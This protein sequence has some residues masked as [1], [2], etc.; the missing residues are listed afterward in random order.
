MAP[1]SSV[2]SLKP[3]PRPRPKS[4]P[5]FRDQLRTWRATAAPS[6]NPQKSHPSRQKRGPEQSESNNRE[7]PGLNLDDQPPTSAQARWQTPPICEIDAVLDPF[8]RFPA[9]LP[10]DG[11][12]LIHF[13]ITTIA[14]KIYGT[15]R[16]PGFSSVRDVSFV[17]ALTS[18]FT[19]QWMVISAEALLM[20]YRGAPEP[21]SLFRRKAVAYLALQKYLEDFSRE[22]VTD[23]IVSGL[24]MAIIAESRIAGPQV[25]N[26]HL[27][28]YEAVIKVGGGLR[29]VLAASPRPFD[30]MSHFMPYLICEPLA[31]AL[32]FSEEFEDQAMDLL[33]IIV[34]G[35]SSADPA[36]L[37]FTVSHEIARPQVLF[38]SLRGSLPQQ[39]RRLLLFSVIAP[40]LRVDMWEGRLYVQKSSHFLSLFLLV[41]TFWKLRH[42]Y[43]SQTAF[44]SSLYRLFMN[45]ATRNQA[46]SW[47]LTE[48]G[49][50]WV[51]VKA[52][53]DVYTNSSDR[54][55]RLKN[56]IDFLAEAVSA[57]KLFRVTYDNVRKRMA[58]YL[59]Q[60]LTGASDGPG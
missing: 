40:Y 55:V 13:Y 52:C 43:R 31:D 34:K 28:A 25:S 32:V 1:T 16:N 37:I 6:R 30:Q 2:D 14:N 50:F 23:E 27:K 9:D 33:R 38:L 51:V 18:P 46:G 60:C 19:L 24:I 47:L 15:K 12:R 17:A 11:R 53:F 22:K 45:S 36:E 56:Y 39:I 10:A 54:E 35:E 57:L 5:V 59:Y 20:R 41:S 7:P 3:K 29:Q 44:F 8:C 58:I 49:F 48:E 21:P 4:P 26:L 42:D